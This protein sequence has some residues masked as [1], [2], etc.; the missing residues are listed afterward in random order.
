MVEAFASRGSACGVID[1]FGATEGGLAVT[2]VDGA[3]AG[4]SGRPDPS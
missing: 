4:R 3:P 1:G 2:R